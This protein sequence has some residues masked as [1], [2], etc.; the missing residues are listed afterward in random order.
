MKTRIF[1]KSIYVVLLLVLLT[2]SNSCS[3]LFTNPLKDKKTGDDVTVLLI[4]LNFFETKFKIHVLDAETEEYISGS[5]IN[6]FLSGKSASNVVNFSGEKK[7]SYSTSSG[8]LELTYDPNIEVS[9]ANPVEFELQATSDSYFSFPTQVKVIQKGNEDIYIYA[10]R[11]SNDKS[12]SVVADPFT[13]EYAPVSGLT[14]LT[15][16]QTALNLISSNYPEYLVWA[17]YMNSSAG[18]LEA[19][20]FNGDPNLYSEWGFHYYYMPNPSERSN[21][22]ALKTNSFSKG[23]YI[24][25]A[26]LKRNGISKCTDGIRI[27]YTKAGGGSG[28]TGIQYL[29]TLSDNTIKK[30]L[31]SGTLPF[32]KT[33]NHFYYP[34]AAPSGV[35]ELIGDSQFELN[36]HSITFENV[37]NSNQ[38]NVEMTPRSGLTHCIFTYVITCEEGQ[39]LGAAITF[40]MQIKEHGEETSWSWIESGGGVCELWLKKNTQYDIRFNWDGEWNEFSITTDYDNIE[41]FIE[42]QANENVSFFPT[43]DNP[44]GL[45]VTNQADT[46]LII[47]ANVQISGTFCDVL[48]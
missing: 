32:S 18:T 35:L 29:L 34:T 12:A 14:K 27:N 15:L 30:G 28:T 5:D 7:D 38:L 6:I 39:I 46:L 9:T 3:D 31:H 19:K 23:N 42:S 36:P 40:N 24:I 21:G 8:Y 47:N 48:N 37:C 25:P 1:R 20:N 45:K 44:D 4:D 13:M 11:V 10:F 16:P 33:I 26:L 17:I 2:I 43:Q 22:D 41:S